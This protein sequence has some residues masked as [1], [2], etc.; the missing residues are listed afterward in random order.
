M[1]ETLI[2]QFPSPKLNTEDPACKVLLGPICY[3]ELSKISRISL[4][5]SLFTGQT[6]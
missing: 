2:Q 3:R 5:R 4:V 1:L 6:H